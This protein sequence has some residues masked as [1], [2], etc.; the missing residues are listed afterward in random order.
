MEALTCTRSRRA[1]DMRK[2]QVW[3]AAFSLI[4]LVLFLFA[5]L[6]YV[7]THSENYLVM[8]LVNPVLI[9]LFAYQAVRP[10]SMNSSYLLLATGLSLLLC[11]VSLLFLLHQ[12]SGILLFLTLVS[13]AIGVFALGRYVYLRQKKQ[14]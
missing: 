12:Y 8:C 4:W 10:N 14:Q 2:S 11:I 13:F 6:N 7:Q 5:L 3:S 9:I 1:Q